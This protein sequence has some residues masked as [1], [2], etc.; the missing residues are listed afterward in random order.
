MAYKIVFFDIDGTLLDEEKKVPADTVEAIRRLQEKGVETVIA[1]GRAPYF[2]QP[3]AKQLGI[4]SYV[5]L[6]GA[7]VVHQGKPVYKRVIAPTDL[8]LLVE[9][10]GKNGH[11]LVFEGAEAFYSNAE[12]HPRVFT[13]VS[14][15]KVDQPGYDPEFWK[16]ED[17]FQV[18]LHNMV[19][20]EHLYEN[21]V[22]NLRMIRWH[23]HAMDV[24]PA[25]GSKGE[26]IAKLLEYLELSPSEAVAFGDGLNDIEM[27]VEAGLGIAMGNS[28]EEVKPH[29]NY[30]TTHVSKGGIRNGLV[31]AGLLEE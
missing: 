28:H 18:F 16:K 21:A 3:L 8:E 24:L 23:E 4:T 9:A 5:S 12:S 10:A 31:Y 22:P 11:P 2:F 1:T 30:V 20:E 27:L 17:I 25:S 26:G 6:N 13:S 15:L 14:S 7:Y 19:D 29:A